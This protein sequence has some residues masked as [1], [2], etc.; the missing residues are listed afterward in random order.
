M[1]YRKMSKTAKVQRALR[2]G[3]PISEIVERYGVRASTVYTVR[4]Q[5]RKTGQL[6][7][8]IISSP[9]VVV[10]TQE[11]PAAPV[12]PVAP[13]APAGL[14]T[15]NA[16]STPSAPEGLQY[17]VASKDVPQGIPAMVVEVEKKPSLWGRFKLWAFGLR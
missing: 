10:D 17:L 8:I 12:A 3:L 13:V 15:L 9:P 7:T 1:P 6:P 11:Q 16:P 14:V 5:M 4:S 2:N